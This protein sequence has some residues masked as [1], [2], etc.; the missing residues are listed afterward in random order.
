MVVMVG[1]GLWALG[2]GLGLAMQ[3]HLLLLPPDGARGRI[4]VLNLRSCVFGICTSVGTLGGPPTY[5]LQTSYTTYHVV[6][7][8]SKRGSCI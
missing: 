8:L 1:T 3:M 6:K 4:L 7:A 2:A 5:L